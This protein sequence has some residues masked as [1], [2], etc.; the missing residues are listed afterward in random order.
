MENS[1]K[2]DFTW[3]VC[4]FGQTKE[5]TLCSGCVWGDCFAIYNENLIS[6][7]QNCLSYFFDKT[8]RGNQLLLQNYKKGKKNIW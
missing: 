3:R 4:R 8:E 6:Y 2:R 1:M 5:D 7:Q